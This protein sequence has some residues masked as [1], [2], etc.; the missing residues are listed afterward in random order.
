MVDDLFDDSG[1]GT[2]V[3][4][5]HV[6]PGAGRTSVVGRHGDAL[7]VKV[8]APPEQGRA[9]EACAA[10]IASILGV[11]PASVTITGGETSRSKRFKVADIERDDLVHRLEL[12]LEDAP[13]GGVRPGGNARGRRGVPGTP[14]R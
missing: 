7:K 8:A 3:L 13:L 11:K 9:N 14:G 2:F 4:K 1:D 12:A 5:L 6:Q 10:L